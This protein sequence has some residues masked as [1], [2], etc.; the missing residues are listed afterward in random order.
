WIREQLDR[1][2]IAH[3]FVG[4]DGMIGDDFGVNILTRPQLNELYNAADLYL[5]PSRWEGG[6]QSV[7]E[8]AACRCK[9]LSTP[10]GLARDILEPA[11]LFRSAAEGAEILARDIRESSLTPTIGP[12]FS[13]WQANHTTPVMAEKLRELYG[14]LAPDPDFISRTERP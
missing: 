5:V 14:Q 9:I 12:Q 4:R 6:P 1:E 8:A 11:S 10:L 13:R 3:T 2:G 7:M